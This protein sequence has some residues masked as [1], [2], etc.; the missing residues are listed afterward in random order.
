MKSF[1]T[2]GGILLLLST[3][4]AYITHIYWSLS[5]MF[6]GKM[7]TINDAVLAI[8]GAIIAP[9]GAAHGYYLWFT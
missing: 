5:M 6:A 8:L 4:P 7:D 1:F 9:I 3:I 2:A